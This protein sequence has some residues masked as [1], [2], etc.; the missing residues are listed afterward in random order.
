MQTLGVD[1]WRRPLDDGTA[2]IVLGWV[3][4]NHTALHAGLVDD[5]LKVLLVLREG[6]L[7]GLGVRE[8]LDLRLGLVKATIDALTILNKSILIPVCLLVEFFSILDVVGGS[9]R[10]QLVV[11]VDLGRNY[12]L[13]VS[14]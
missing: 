4:K 13:C 1:L 12:L 14:V 10:G 6:L 9:H 2:C 7:I 5:F 11:A 8:G 3:L